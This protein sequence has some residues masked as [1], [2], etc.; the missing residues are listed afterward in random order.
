MMG[1]QDEAKLLLDNK[2]DV[3]ARDAKGITPLGYAEQNR[4]KELAEL[5]RQRGGHD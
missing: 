3:N 1:F 4:H 5:L 2:A